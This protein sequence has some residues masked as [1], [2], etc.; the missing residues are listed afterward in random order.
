MRKLAYI[1]L[2]FICAAGFGQENQPDDSL[3]YWDAYYP[4][5]I[6][7]EGKYN[8]PTYSDYTTVIK[9]NPDSTFTEDATHWKTVSGKTITS[10]TAYLYARGSFDDEGSASINFNQDNILIGAYGSGDRPRM[11]YYNLDV[12][13]N[14]VVIRDIKVENTILY[15]GL[16]SVKYRNITVYNSDIYTENGW[17]GKEDGG[18]SCFYNQI[19]IIRT[20]VS[21]AIYDGIFMEGCDTVNIDHAL[22]YN[23]NRS[24][25]TVTTGV[26]PVGDGIQLSGCTN[27]EI[28]NSIVSRR[29]TGHKFCI[30]VRDSKN[31]LS[32]ADQVGSIHNNVLLGQ[33]QTNPPNSS[34]TYGGGSR[35]YWEEAHDCDFYNNYVSQDVFVSN[36]HLYSQASNSGLKIH[37]NKIE[38]GSHPFRSNNAD[39][40]YNNTVVDAGDTLD[41]TLSG[42]TIKNNILTNDELGIDASNLTIETETEAALFVNAAD[43]NYN[44][45]TTSN[46]YQSASTFAGINTNWLT[47]LQGNNFTQTTFNIGAY[48]EALPEEYINIDT[49]YA[50]DDDGNVITNTYD[51]NNLTRWSSDVRGVNAVFVL[52][53]FRY[54]D[55]IGVKW[56]NN[57]RVDTFK[58]SIS[59]DSTNWYGTS[60]LTSQAVSGYQYFDIFGPANYFRYT[61]FGNSVS[62]WNSIDEIRFFGDTIAAVSLDTISYQIQNTWSKRDI[63]INSA[64]KTVISNDTILITDPMSIRRT[65][66]NT[67]IDW[68]IPNDTIQGYSGDEFILKFNAAV[69]AVS[70]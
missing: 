26:E 66:T 35:V 61:G 58:L 18:I 57:T 41:G 15:L 52:D 4:G 3:A 28:W 51:N 32:G 34:T 27:Y 65:K 13:A 37:G 30:I 54:A 6:Y 62:D 68:A 20:V 22:I 49:A 14:N 8:I 64:I 67:F 2:L 42:A 40:F 60:I 33:T 9:I 31:I 16:S 23:V 36:T 39:Y 50:E 24:W 55:S 25:F 1:A 63:I 46:A 53:S 12:Q 29:G 10:N 45:K 5:K 43:S 69:N 47:D 7:P 48:Q 59:T 38:G 44:V 70:Q 11:T 17:T 56:V 19:N 21:G